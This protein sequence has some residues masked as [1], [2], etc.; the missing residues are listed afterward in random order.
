M[1]SFSL[2]HCFIVLV[3]L[4]VS[5]IG[6]LVLFYDIC[7]FHMTNKH[8]IDLIMI[9][10]TDDS[11]ILTVTTTGCGLNCILNNKLVKFYWSRN[12]IIIVKCHLIIVLK[13]SLL[14]LLDVG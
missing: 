6:D 14:S 7:F 9:A 8:I 13:V 4:G 3:V 5:Y 10:I 1:L 2:R 11:M 12:N